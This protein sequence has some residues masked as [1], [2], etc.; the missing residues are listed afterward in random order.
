MVGLLFSFYFTIVERAD[1]K[2]KYP[3]KLSLFLPRVDGFREGDEIYLRGL[4]FGEILEI[5]KVSY[6][7]VKNPKFDLTP[8]QSAVELSLV[9]KNPVTLWDNYRVQFKTKTLFS[10][11]HLDIDPGFPEGEF[12]LKA[13]PFA[14]DTPSTDYT[15]DLFTIAY[16]VLKENRTDLRRIVSSSH[17]ISSKLNG[18]KGTLPR[19]VN[20][21]ELYDATE[22][23][24]YDMGIVSKEAR[25]YIE[26]Q[27]E[28]DIHPMTFTMVVF[29]NLMGISIL[30]N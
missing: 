23:F 12:T 22:H 2:G 6:Y 24:V 14:D 30:S 16:D 10:S 28:T 4:L 26:N 8:D 1:T 11:R 5:R 21:D 29:F 20:E 17:S 13:N 7:E 27:R 15:D 19:L 9:V 18:S 25:R 3:Y